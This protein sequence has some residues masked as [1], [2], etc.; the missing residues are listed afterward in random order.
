MQLASLIMER[1]SGL[2]CPLVTSL[3]T[4]SSGRGG[5]K[6]TADDDLVNS[7]LLES[8]D[9]RERLLDWCLHRDGQVRIL[10]LSVC[11]E[12][13]NSFVKANTSVRSWLAV[14]GTCPGEEDAFVEA[15]M[16]K[17]R[18]LQVGMCIRL[19]HCTLKRCGLPLLISSPVRKRVTRWTNIK[20]WWS[21]WL[22]QFLLE[23]KPG[24]TIWM[25]CLFNWRER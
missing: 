20:A 19:L 25:S 14:T 4:T 1:L 11:G 8:G 22:K 9:L 21:N 6:S 24:G 16:V 15:T 10:H 13:E 2:D 3:H 7:L 23:L 12:C 17:A 5:Q 18:Q